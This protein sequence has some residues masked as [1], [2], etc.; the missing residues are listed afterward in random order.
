MCVGLGKRRTFGCQFPSLRQYHFFPHC[1]EYLRSPGDNAV[2]ICHL[3]VVT[4]RSQSHTIV[5]WLMCSLGIWTWVLT[6]A[7]QVHFPLSHPLSPCVV[8]SCHCSPS[9]YISQLHSLLSPDGSCLSQPALV[10][11]QLLQFLSIASFLGYSPSLHLDECN[12]PRLYF[13][14]E[15]GE[16]NSSRELVTDI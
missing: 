4:L 5:S 10:L 2:P 14:S 3:T 7:W 15:G 9:C 13:L 16:S 6:C 12:S 1:E 11:W 8:N